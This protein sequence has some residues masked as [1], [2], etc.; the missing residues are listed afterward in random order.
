MCLASFIGDGDYFE[1]SNHLYLMC[2]V[3]YR[4]FQVAASKR[5]LFRIK[6]NIKHKGK[7]PYSKDFCNKGDPWMNNEEFIH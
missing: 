6:W 4:K 3:H 2:M 7:C 1:P 5:Y